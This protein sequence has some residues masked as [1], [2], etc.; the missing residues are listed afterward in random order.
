MLGARLVEPGSLLDF[1]ASNA[2]IRSFSSLTKG[3]SKARVASRA[4][5]LY[6]L[7]TSLNWFLA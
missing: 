1:G 7:Q 2:P 3:D 5:V 4:R 6:R